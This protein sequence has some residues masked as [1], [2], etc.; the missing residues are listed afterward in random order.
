MSVAYSETVRS[1]KLRKEI[2]HLLPPYIALGFD[3]QI[4]AKSQ[5]QRAREVAESQPQKTPEVVKS[6]PQRAPEIVDMGD[7][8]SIKHLSQYGRPLCVMS[9]SE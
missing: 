5:A 3:Q 9:S 7:L 6:Q 8:R 2:A 4:I 1:L